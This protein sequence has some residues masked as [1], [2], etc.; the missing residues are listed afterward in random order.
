MDARG[1]RQH[2]LG[3]VHHVRPGTRDA[4]NGPAQPLLKGSNQQR[5]VLQG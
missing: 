1:P 3:N 5:T 2:A 4:D